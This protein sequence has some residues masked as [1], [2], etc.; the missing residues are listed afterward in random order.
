MQVTLL[1]SSACI[2][3]GAVIHQIYQPGTVLYWVLVVTDSAQ[4]SWLLNV[5]YDKRKQS[6]KPTEA[7]EPLY[8][9]LSC[10]WRSCCHKEVSC[11]MPS[12][13]SY[14][15][16]QNNLAK[17]TN[18]NQLGP[19]FSSRNHASDEEIY[20]QA[21]TDVHI[22]QKCGASSTSASLKQLSQMKDEILQKSS[23][24]HQTSWLTELGWL[25]H[26]IRG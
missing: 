22:S 13:H 7:P 11:W 24:S 19:L 8:T 3:P 16:L 2:H 25:H 14:D 12:V 1:S 6:K 23:F 18:E 26:R 10:L 5:E 20:A 15:M 21:L 4:T 9:K 17:T